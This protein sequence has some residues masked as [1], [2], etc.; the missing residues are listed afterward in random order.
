MSNQV[1]MLRS[2]ANYAYLTFTT[3]ITAINVE[4]SPGEQHFLSHLDVPANAQCCPL[5][6]TSSGSMRVQIS[7]CGLT[8]T[9]QKDLT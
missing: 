4:E 2:T 7:S 3:I 9:V 1:Q 6:V 8:T 5:Q